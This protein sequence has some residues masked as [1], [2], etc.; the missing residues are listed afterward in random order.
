MLGLLNKFHS[1]QC[2]YKNAQKKWMV[3]YGRMPTPGNGDAI[4]TAVANSAQGSGKIWR[5]RCRTCDWETK[6]GRVRYGRRCLVFILETGCLLA[7]GTGFK[8]R[9]HKRIISH[10]FVSNLAVTMR[11]C[12]WIPWCTSYFATLHFE[13]M[14]VIARCHSCQIDTNNSNTNIPPCFPVSR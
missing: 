3:K 10:G 13:I 14:K 8:F 12:T 4:R 11:I 9:L 7:C 1:R 5:M 2:P 6:G